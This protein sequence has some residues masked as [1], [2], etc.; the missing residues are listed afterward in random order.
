MQRKKNIHRY[1]IYRGLCWFVVMRTGW[2]Y[3]S[4][5]GKIIYTAVPKRTKEEKDK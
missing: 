2:V 5:S 3:G 1:W 4:R